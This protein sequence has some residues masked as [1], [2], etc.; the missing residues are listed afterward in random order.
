M[1]KVSVIVPVY[2]VE[3]YLG[4][5]VESLI[6]QTLK[7]IEIILVDD[8]SPD[9]CPLICDEYAAKDRRIT[10]LHKKNGGVSAARNDGLK[11][12]HGEYIIFCDSD[13]WME[14]RAFEVLVN[15]A[16]NSNADIAI[17]DVYQVRGEEKQHS[18]FYEHN[19]T[20]DDKTY[21]EKL[22]EADIYR[23]YC[24]MPPAGGPAFGYGGPWNK[25]VKRRLLVDNNICFDLRVKG[26]FDD[27]LY[28]AHILACANKVSYVSVPV[29]NYRIVET[30]ITHSY[31]PNVI[32]INNAIFEA[33]QE[34]FYEQKAN[35]RFD[36]AFYACVLRRIEESIKLYYVNPKNPKTKR[37][38]MK[39]YSSMLKS[40]I[41]RAAIR[42]VDYSKIS[43]KQKLIVLFGRAGVALPIWLLFSKY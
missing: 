28:T 26:I 40:P 33:W 29:Y 34:F 18:V 42:N 12:A 15:A 23:T 11:I 3:K 10:V 21:I 37:E 20:T 6:K 36:K 1:P 19:F 27:I 16:E 8:G 30:S 9:R 14:E 43:K 38:L 13:D 5:C 35:G 7:D 17:G 25:L 39:E 22:I 31:K 32:E 4:N 24:P 2:K 41:Y